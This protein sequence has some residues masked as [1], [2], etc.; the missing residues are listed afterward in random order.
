M[1]KI[2]IAIFTATVAFV[3]AMLAQL[4]SHNL[5]RRREN[6]KDKKI[7]V[8]E[9]VLPVL[10]DVILYI[11]TEMDFRKGHD[12]EVEIDSK[13]IIRKISNNVKYGNSKLINA[14]FKYKQ[15]VTFFDGRGGNERRQTYSVFYFFLDYAIDVLHRSDYTDEYLLD[16]ID[17]SQKLSGLAYLLMDLLGVEEALRILSYKWQL[18]N[19]FWKEI[20]NDSLDIILSEKFS[21]HSNVEHI[22]ISVL[23]ALI[24]SF[25][26]NGE[27]SGT[28]LIKN[29]K[30]AVE[31]V[32]GRW[33]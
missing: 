13:E 16:I 12:V 29:L 1:S 30:S 31:V 27:E 23:N 6:I 20:S 19:E 11:D 18:T 8:Q 17:K 3:A 22:Q 21:K 5:T 15:S 24:G 26:K 32:E 33:Q 7:V 4:L 28:E 10:N 25:E 9:L 14:I 2:E